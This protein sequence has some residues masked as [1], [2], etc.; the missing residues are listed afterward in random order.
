ME[1]VIHPYTTDVAELNNHKQ[2]PFYE[3]LNNFIVRST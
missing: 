3:C 2:V 1:E